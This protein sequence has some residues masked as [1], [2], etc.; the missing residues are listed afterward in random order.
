MNEKIENTH[1]ET[2]WDIEEVDF[3]NHIDNSHNSL[4]SNIL[5]EIYLTQEKTNKN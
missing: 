2:D 3:S 1:L 4:I 5:I